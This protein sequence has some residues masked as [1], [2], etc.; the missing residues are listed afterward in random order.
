M[1]G[2]GRQSQPYMVVD[3]SHDV[4]Y[5]KTSAAPQGKPVFVKQLSC[6][7]GAKKKEA[8]F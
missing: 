4:R 6:D 5:G 8:A 2:F 1:L 7:F 3:A